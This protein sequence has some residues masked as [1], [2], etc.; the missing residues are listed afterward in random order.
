L[1]AIPAA[2]GVTRGSDATPA[3]EVQTFRSGRQGLW[4]A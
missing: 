2:A 4:L 1:A 3:A